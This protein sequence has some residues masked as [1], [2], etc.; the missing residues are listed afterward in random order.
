MAKANSTC[1]V[2]DCEG[3]VKGRGW[4]SKHYERWRKYGDLDR[5]EL[6]R[7]NKPQHSGCN[8]GGCGGKHFAKKMCRV[9]YRAAD[10]QAKR[11]ERQEQM[12]AYRSDPGNREKAKATS[13]A[14]REANPERA[15]AASRA[16]YQANRATAL[17]Y[18]TA[19]RQANRDQVRINN[20]KRKKRMATVAVSDL[21]V[22]QWQDIKAAWDHRCAYCGDT[23]ENLTM[24]HYLPI[25]KGGNHTASNIVPACMT[26]NCKK[27]DGPPPPFYYEQAA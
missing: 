8:V 2:P 23:P 3:T 25:V 21:T 12:Q 27:N 22:Q 14:W 26:C 1:S 4:C 24:D 16:W 6:P 13:R 19:Y 20:A 9:H 18:R 10:Y 7:Q 11:A 5:V 15:V 17:D